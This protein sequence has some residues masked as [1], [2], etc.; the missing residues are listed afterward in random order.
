M[1]YYHVVFTLPASIAAIGYYNKELIYGLLFEVASQT[2]R[3]IAADPK[4]LGARI[5][6][7]LLLH[8]WGSALTHHPL[9]AMARSQR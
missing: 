1:E 4:H 7:T 2:L 6:A 9:P 5:G 8:T 3:T